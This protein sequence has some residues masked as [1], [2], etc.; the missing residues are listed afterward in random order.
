MVEINKL[1]NK[2]YLETN[3]FLDM[4]REQLNLARQKSP[5][6]SEQLSLLV[7]ELEEKVLRFPA[8]KISE[9]WGQVE[10]GDRSLIESLMGN[11][12]GNT[13]KE[14]INSVNN[15][16]D[17]EAYRQSK[18]Q[19]KIEKIL[20]NLLFAEIFA[21]LITD[22]NASVTGFLF[23]A[24]LAALMGGTSI[25][26]DDPA[27]VGAAPGALPIEDVQLAVRLGDSDDE[28]EMY[29]YSLKVL[30]D[31]GEVKGSFVNLVDYFLDPSEQRK[32]DSIVYLV[33]IKRHSQGAEGGKVWTGR[34]DFYEFTIR[35]DNFL[36]WIG[37]PIDKAVK[38]WI[39]W[40]VPYNMPAG[41]TAQLKTTDGELVVPGTP[42]DKGLELLRYEKTGEMEKV[43][44]ASGKKLY[45][46]AE[47]EAI[48][49]ALQ[50]DE[51]DRE[52]FS[53]LTNTPGYTGNLQWHIAAGKYQRPEYW[54]GTLNLSNETL[55][56]AANEYAQDLNAGLVQIFNALSDLT[57]QVSLYFM[58][59][60]E[61][62]GASRKQHGKMAIEN[63][64]IL[65][66]NTEELISED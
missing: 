11:V 59:G 40:V 17:I 44:G 65:K 2:Y 13:V 20:S 26:V 29:P 57:S 55:V 14:K 51:I 5:I 41:K 7:E 56:E 53:T 8:I 21:S 38:A 28:R 66:Q 16:L 32:T 18:D 43:L 63:A 10:N 24:F 39:P 58:G 22:Y 30:S 62:D 46:P 12:E 49:T 47:Y 27:A 23:E 1:V 54:I 9:L 42:L 6:H 36:D 19:H 64:R 37:Y 3:A 31:K 60:G 52:V 25:Q 33:V 15:F 34:L 50:A 4:I 48:S 45:S 35:R 61:K